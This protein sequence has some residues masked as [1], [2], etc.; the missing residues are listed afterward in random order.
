[1]KDMQNPG[2]VTVL[3]AQF[4]E[5]LRDLGVSYLAINSNK[6]GYKSTLHTFW[7]VMKKFL[8]NIREYDHVSIHGTANHYII[9]AP[10]II[11]FAKLFGKSVSLRKFAGN[12]NDLYEKADPLRK[13]LIRYVLRNADVS[14]FE[15]KYL[16]EYFH[17]FNPNTFWF[18]NV[19]RRPEN[20]APK[21]DYRKRFVYISHLKDEKGTQEL[22]EA[23][24]RLDESFDLKIYGPV[25]E[26]R[27]TPEYIAQFNTRY[28]GVLKPSE[29]VEKLKEADVLVLPS[30]REGYPGIVIEAY[31]VGRPVLVTNLPAVCEIVEDGKTG[32]LVPPR[33]VDALVEGFYRFSAEN[34]SDFSKNAY[35][36]FENF[37][38]LPQTRNFLEKISAL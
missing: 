20:S 13:Y 29:V 37:D 34:Y 18:P 30:H 11:F 23:A 31:S 32:V 26:S 24:K 35:A 2:G 15:T 1:M 22:L 8:L 21:S 6:S 3:F 36:A 28:E 5:D 17:S 9:I 10:F 14:F 4:L 33:D 27:Y 19:R 16:V 7:G 38:S 12:F 25:H